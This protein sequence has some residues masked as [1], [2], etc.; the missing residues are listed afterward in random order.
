MFNVYV[1]RVGSALMS[2]LTPVLFL[3]YADQTFLR[4]NF[5]TNLQVKKCQVLFKSCSLFIV[6]AAPLQSSSFSERAFQNLFFEMSSLFRVLFRLSRSESVTAFR[7]LIIIYITLIKLESKLSLF[8][9]LEF[10]LILQYQKLNYP[11]HFSAH[12]RVTE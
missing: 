2:M 5:F 1:R 4:T 11:F 10:V 8:C 3:P 9:K 12:C 6:L 7:M